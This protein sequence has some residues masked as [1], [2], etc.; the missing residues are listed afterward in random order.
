MYH[1]EMYTAKWGNDAYTWKVLGSPTI[2]IDK[3]V[4]G[5]IFTGVFLTLLVGP[6]WFFSEVGGF[7]APNPVKKAYI[8]FAFVITK[9]LT[10][11]AF[12]E[13]SQT[14]SSLGIFELN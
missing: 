6:L 10:Q 11:E 8:S 2:K 4:F 3:C 14:N 9:N 5:V 13:V 12:L 1:W 7:I